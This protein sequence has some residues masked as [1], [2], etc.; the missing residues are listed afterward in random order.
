VEHLG[1]ETKSG[2]EKPAAMATAGAR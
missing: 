1:P 2:L